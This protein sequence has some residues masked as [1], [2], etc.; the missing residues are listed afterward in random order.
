V[1]LLP[2][3]NF[4]NDICNFS[5]CIHATIA[6]GKNL[7]FVSPLEHKACHHGVL[8]AGDDNTTI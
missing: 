7:L 5:E 4:C 3:G 2:H 8:A 6:P 1:Q